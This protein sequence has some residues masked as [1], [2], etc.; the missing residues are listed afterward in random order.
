MSKHTQETWKV[1]W[2]T[3]VIYAD[4]PERPIIA[5]ISGLDQCGKPSPFDLPRY[6][7]NARLIVSAPELLAALEAATERMEAVA[8]G[9]PVQNRHKGVSQRAHVHHMAGHLAQH[10]KR[11]RAVLSEVEGGDHAG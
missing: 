10:A 5:W 4:T 7:A 3:G 8:E 9:I 1:D 11:A 2:V 6:E